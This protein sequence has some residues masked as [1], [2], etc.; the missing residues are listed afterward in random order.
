MQFLI[1]QKIAI[2]EFVVTIRCQSSFGILF[3]DSN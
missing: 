1:F 3:S 2:D